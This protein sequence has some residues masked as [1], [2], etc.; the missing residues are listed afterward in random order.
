[1][2]SL[3]HKTLFALLL[4]AT[5]SAFAATPESHLHEIEQKIYSIKHAMTSNKAQ[6][7]ELESSLRTLELQI[8]K[9]TNQLH[10]LHHK[11][12]QLQKTLHQLKLDYAKYQQKIRHT[13][14][15]MASILR[16]EYRVGH[17]PRLSVLLSSDSVTHTQVQLTYLQYLEKDRLN[18]LATLKQLLKLEQ[19][20]I[21]LQTKNMNALEKSQQK[22]Q[23]TLNQ[24]NQ[25]HQQRQH[26]LNQISTTLSQQASTL[27]TLKANKKHLESVIAALQENAP[28]FKAIG[29][30]FSSLKHQLP[31]PT[32]G[33]LLSLFG[34]RIDKTQLRWNGVLFKAALGQ[35]VHAVADGKVIFAN[36]MPGYG[37]L[38][39]IYHGQDYM[40]LYGRNQ[41]LFKRVGD[42]VH[43]GDE[44]ALVGNS[45][46][47]QTSS[48]YF[49][50]RHHSKPINPRTWLR[51]HF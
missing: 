11:I 9:Q 49:E 23:Q 14:H 48:L 38:L 4:L 45:G 2:R 34:S 5:I 10:Q 36:W 21:D 15:R 3:I 32:H 47:Y 8:S 40:T 33:K 39:I 43:A 27:K 25:L 24:L 44:I 26:L 46:G 12:S 31:W 29:K 6:Q 17:E 16:T 13:K 37:L 41:A 28:Y 20:N 35:P 19:D 50:L 42:I 18:A 1:M 22:M 7:S 51:S 30:P